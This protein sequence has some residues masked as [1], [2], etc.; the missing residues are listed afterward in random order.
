MI[1]KCVA[2]EDDYGRSC[3]FSR[4]Y[5]LLVH[6]LIFSSDDGAFGNWLL[7]F[8]VDLFNQLDMLALFIGL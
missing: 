5:R 8:L 6:S 2:V 1:T 4:P 3:Q 7:A